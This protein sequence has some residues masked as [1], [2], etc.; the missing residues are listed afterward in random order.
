[1]PRLETQDSKRKCKSRRQLAGV[2]IDVWELAGALTRA[3]WVKLGET[4]I[5]VS[6]LGPVIVSAPPAQHL[7]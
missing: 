7:Q 6:P 4:V 2:P 3:H 1:M 5:P